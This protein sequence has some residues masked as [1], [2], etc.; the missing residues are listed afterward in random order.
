MQSIYIYILAIFFNIIAIGLIYVLWVICYK[1]NNKKLLFISLGCT[2]LI[3]IIFIELPL[4][5]NKLILSV[6]FSYIAWKILNEYA[7]R[8]HKEM[9]TERLESMRPSYKKFAIKDKK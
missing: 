5:V 2:A 4:Y 3:E 1:R 9:V 6:L 7:N 8:I